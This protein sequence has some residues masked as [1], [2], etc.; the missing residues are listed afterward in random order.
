MTDL[1]EVHEEMV[2]VQNKKLEPL[3][4]PDQPP[5]KV[6]TEPGLLLDLWIRFQLLRL[7]LSIWE[8]RKIREWLGIE[9]EMEIVAQ[10]VRHQHM[11][12][13]I[14]QEDNDVRFEVRDKR[15]R[16]L[17][18]RVDR[19]HEMQTSRIKAVGKSVADIQKALPPNWL[20]SKK[21]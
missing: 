16:E 8:K 4:A 17:S 2:V 6:T 15:F 10:H 14:A 21:K 20:K 13:D 11:G 3:D 7:R 5:G 1:H 19:L 18:D 12:M 9:R